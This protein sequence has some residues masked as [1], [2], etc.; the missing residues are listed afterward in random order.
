MSSLLE[1]D[2]LRGPFS[3]RH[4]LDVPSEEHV[5]VANR[6]ELKRLPIWVL[7]SQEGQP[8]LRDCRGHHLSRV[9]VWLFCP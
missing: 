5:F 9:S 2:Y 3:E 4:P 1:R 6:A 8:L 7:P